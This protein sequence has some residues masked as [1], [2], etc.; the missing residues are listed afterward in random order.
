MRAPRVSAEDRGETARGRLEREQERVCERHLR[1]AQVLAADE[2]DRLLVPG[3]GGGGVREQAPGGGAC[4][5]IRGVGQDEGHVGLM[6]E[7]HC[8]HDGGRLVLGSI[9]CGCRYCW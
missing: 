7:M 9:L 1:E 6:R 5:E 3:D 8:A 4:E 2:A